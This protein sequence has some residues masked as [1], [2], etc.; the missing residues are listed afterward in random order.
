MIMPGRNFTATNE[1]RYGFNGQ[2]KGDDAVSGNYTAQF[3]QYDSRIGRRW[4][5]DPK[6]TV[7]ISVY[8]TFFNNPISNMDILGDTSTHASKYWYIGNI[9][10]FKTRGKISDKPIENIPNA[11]GNGVIDVLNIF[12][13]LWNSG[14][15]NIQGI[16]EGTWSKDVSNEIKTGFNNTSDV[17]Y[18]T[19]N[20]TINT[21]IKQ[22]I[23]DNLNALDN[24]TSLEFA[25]SFALTFYGPKGFS[26]ANQYAATSYL[27]AGDIGTFS[28][29]EGFSLRIYSKDYVYHNS[30]QAASNSRWA[31]PSSFSSSKEAFNALALDYRNTTNFAQKKFSVRSVGLFIKG[32]A[33]PQGATL[34]GGTQLLSTP[35]G[36]KTSLTYTGWFK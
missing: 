32:T 19:L 11:I 3:W 28:K 25:T 15:K 13:A 4:N 23:K 33:A 24:P 21:P 16:R 17:V 36:L 18:N 6:P 1:Y 22:Q 31:S 8:S 10:K 7:G 35:F 5:E 27:A 29:V 34:G 30:T 2:E 26:S 20:Y 9:S 12:P 14:V